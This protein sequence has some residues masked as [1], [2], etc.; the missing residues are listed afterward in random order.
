MKDEKIVMQSIPT[1]RWDELLQSS[2]PDGC[3]GVE[4]SAVEGE[5]FSIGLL[6]HEIDSYEVNQSSGVSV[7]ADCGQFGSASS[8]YPDQDPLALL[9]N[10]VANATVVQSEDAAL[11]SL[12]E[13]SSHYEPFPPIDPRLSAMEA[14]DKIA[15]CRRLEKMALAAD[16]RIQRLED[17][18]L[19]TSTNRSILR[20]SLGLSVGAERG[21]AL[22]AVSPIAEE[23]GVVKNGIGYDV[24]RCVEELDFDKIVREATEDAITQLNA[25]PVTSGKYSIVFKNTAMNSILGFFSSVFSA[26]A[27]QKGLSLLAGKEGET[28]ASKAFQLVDDPRH[29]LSLFPV[30]Y[31]AEG[32]AT[33]KKSI[34]EDGKL[35]TLLHNRT[36]AAKAGCET[37]ANA[38]NGGGRLSAGPSN[39]ILLPS[40]ISLDALLDEMGSGLYITDVSGLHAGANAVSGSF[41]LLS[42]GFVVENGKKTDAVDQ[43][44]LSGNIF[45]LFQAVNA[46]S[47]DLRFS[48]GGGVASPAVWVDSL[49]VAGK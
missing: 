5:S 23:N 17:C 46:V 35:V 11:Q 43:I 6:D 3:K 25:K 45:E 39:L 9:Q 18:Q 20:N 40:D 1:Q 31:D 16:P 34:V 38:T 19:V 21:Y 49:T 36:T 4:I 30:S 7:R 26:D 2:L 44:T 33:M 27:A 14:E 15:A 32:V 10:A 22:A 42:R 48:A 28:I 29:P 12:F 41:S 37:T 24:A 13:G 8:E 47:D